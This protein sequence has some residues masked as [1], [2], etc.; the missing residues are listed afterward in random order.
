MTE[1]NSTP[2]SETLTSA[3]AYNGPA[4]DKDAKS[5]AMLCHL[6]AIFTGFLGPLII[7]LV[8]KDSHPFVDDQ[9]KEA[10]NFQI[11]CAIAYLICVPLVYLFCLGFILAIAITI[12]RIIFCILGTIE[13]NKGNAYR[14]PLNLRLIK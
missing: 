9:G 6:L 7:W 10:L 11:A 1:Q 3:I 4:A 14:Y 12:V 13:A 8:K 2:P 5:M